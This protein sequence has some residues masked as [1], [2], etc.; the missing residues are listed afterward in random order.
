MKHEPCT[1]LIS[2]NHSLRAWLEGSDHSKPPP[3]RPPDAVTDRTV[4]SVHSSPSKATGIAAT[5]TSAAA[6]A[7][8]CPSPPVP[9][10]NTQACAVAEDVDLFYLPP[11][12][13]HVSTGDLWSEGTLE[14]TTLSTQCSSATLTTSPQ[15]VMITS[16]VSRPSGDGDTP[17]RGRETCSEVAL[18]LGSVAE[19]GNVNTMQNDEAASE[20]TE[21][22]EVPTPREQLAQTQKLLED[23]Q[24]SLRKKQKLLEDLGRM[25][26]R[27]RALEI[28]E[29]V[30]QRQRLQN[31]VN[32]VELL[33]AM[34]EDHERE[35]SAQ[36]SLCHA[37]IRASTAINASQSTR[38]LCKE[39]SILSDSTNSHVY[40]EVHASCGGV[41]HG[42]KILAKSLKQ[43]S[44]RMH[45]R[46]AAAGSQQSDDRSTH[47]AHESQHGSPEDSGVFV[48]AME[49]TEKLPS[50]RS[51]SV[52]N[53]TARCALCA[54]M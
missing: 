17:S 6:A 7:H 47:D 36:R 54:N 32:Q 37:R 39:P 52:A 16:R 40:D 45:A 19:S 44:K 26:A 9:T 13:H 43:K 4:P 33:V 50:S 23:L 21:A 8:A 3:Q 53:F 35:L 20:R 41:W 34:L 1:S 25:R 30:S 28:T 29:C 14:D 12:P 49:C 42:A 2:F 31:E 38:G 46:A 24:G 15:P 22:S 18:Q 27:K 11:P 51:L 48:A 5:A 10:S